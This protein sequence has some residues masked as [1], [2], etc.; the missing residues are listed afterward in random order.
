MK[1]KRKEGRMEGRFRVE[2]GGRIRV[3]ERE[4]DGG[5]GRR[6]KA[7]VLNTTGT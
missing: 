5:K 3:K 4:R 2:G 1:W 6:I 7:K